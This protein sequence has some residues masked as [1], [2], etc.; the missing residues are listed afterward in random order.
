MAD[1]P[2]FVALRRV[3]RVD[4]LQIADSVGETPAGAAEAV[5]LSPTNACVASG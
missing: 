2:S 4:G 3:E 1:R 5:A